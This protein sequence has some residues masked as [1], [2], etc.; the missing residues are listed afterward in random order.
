VRKALLA[1]AFLLIIWGTIVAATGGV[2][3]RLAGVAIRSRDPFRALMAGLALLL[4]MAA[5]A[6]PALVHDLDWLAE[7]IR[8]WAPALAAVMALTL[9]AHAVWFGSFGV[10]GADAYGYVNQAYDWASGQL[11]RAIPLPMTLPFPGSDEMQI[12]LG[13][14]VGQQAHTMVPTYAPGL[15]LFMAVSLAAGGCGPFFVVPI[16]SVLLVWL[17]FRLGERAAGPLTGLLAALVLIVSPVV[18]YQAAWP[19]SD[20]PAAA[21]WT[22]AALFSLRARRRDALAAGLFA[23]A[24]L[25]VRP[26][27]PLLWAVP[28]VQIAWSSVGRNR[29]ERIGVYAAPAIVP[30]IVVAALNTMWFGAASNSG[31]GA[32][33]ELYQWANVWPNVKLNAAWLWQSQS[34]WVLLALLPLLPLFGRPFDRRVIALCG[35][36]VAAT[37]ACYASYAQFEVWW[38]LRFLLPAAGAFAVLLAGGLASLPRVLPRPFGAI[39]AGVALWLMCSSTL[40]F[41]S[42]AGVFGRMR[43]GERRYV[44]IGEFVAR[45]LP[46]NAALFSSQHS[47]S[48]RF[49]SG[50]LTLRYDSVRKEWAKDVPRAVERAGYHPYLVIDDAETAQ[51][52]EQFGLPADGSLPWPVRARMRELGGLTV[53]DLATAAAD[54]SPTALE[55][56][57]THWCEGRHPL[58]TPRP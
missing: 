35:L 30:A 21:L 18:L 24:G 36:M 45:E 33:G 3:V 6:R 20:V 19:M 14:R 38:Y 29:W 34:P 13:Y 9:G 47:G 49:Y 28:L 11:P 16:F 1:A 57:V 32:P 12:P 15:P 26:N 2:D 17:T 40:T 46:A 51:V 44:D 54:V 50:R 22:G 25:L 4:L 37:F 7:R 52:R 55:P 42:S 23:A 56:G 5:F 31:Y 41:A 53:F 48:L 39:V 27:L 8:R 10:G 43:D 58:V